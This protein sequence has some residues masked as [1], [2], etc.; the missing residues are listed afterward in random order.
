MTE[1]QKK[2]KKYVNAVERKLKVPLKMKVRINADLGTDIHA[3]MEAGWSVDKILEDLGSPKEVADRFNAELGAERKLGGFRYIFLVLGAAAAVYAVY[4]LAMNLYMKSM[5]QR[6]FRESVSLIGGADGPTSIFVSY[7]VGMIG[8]WMMSG[9][10]VLACLDMY[11]FLGSRKTNSLLLS[12]IS[13]GL[14]AAGT[15]SWIYNNGEIFRYWEFTWEFH[16]PALIML[17][18]IVLPFVLL[19]LRFRRRSREKEEQRGML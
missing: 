19:A 13:A 1:D 18:E 6:Q 4:I 16:F 3:R 7:T 2:I 5:V 9:G 12:I 14:A 8:N 17:A 11:R 10:F 15:V